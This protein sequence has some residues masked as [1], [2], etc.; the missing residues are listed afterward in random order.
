MS[1]REFIGEVNEQ[2]AA[3]A[4]ADEAE[5][6]L[7]NLNEAIEALADMIGERERVAAELVP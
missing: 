1:L 7:A 2:V 4:E 5:E 3:L 6:A